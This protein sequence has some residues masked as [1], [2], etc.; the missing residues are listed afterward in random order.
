[1]T[2]GEVLVVSPVNSRRTG[3]FGD[4]SRLLVVLGLVGNRCGLLRV[5]IFSAWLPCVFASFGVIP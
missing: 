4:K 1:M 2:C 3:L 5:G